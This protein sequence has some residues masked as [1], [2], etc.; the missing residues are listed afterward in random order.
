VVSPAG[1]RG[2]VF[3]DYAMLTG[4]VSGPGERAW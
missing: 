3:T 1:P 4:L 2:A